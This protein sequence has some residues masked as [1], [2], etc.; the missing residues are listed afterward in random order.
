MAG[1]GFALARSKP[2]L[3]HL[4]PPCLVAMATILTRSS[5]SPPRPPSG[6]SGGPGRRRRSPPSSRV[7][8]SSA[9]GTGATAGCGFAG[10]LKMIEEEAVAL[11]RG[12][13]AHFLYKVCSGV[14]RLVASDHPLPT[15]QCLRGASLPPF[16]RSGGRAVVPSRPT[17]RDELKG[18]RDKKQGRGT[19]CR[20]GVRGSSCRRARRPCE[21]P[22]SSRSSGSP[23][24]SRCRRCSPPLGCLQARADREGG[25]HAGRRRAA[26]W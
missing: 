14:R 21:L 6:R 5:P 17:R 23:P 2:P 18:A 22:P 19:S 4:L 3:D 15:T 20:G 13:W 9:G 24:S 16:R 12:T 26:S 8:R 10:D 7:A 11:G 25:E 1:A